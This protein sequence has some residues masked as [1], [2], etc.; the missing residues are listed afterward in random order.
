MSRGKVVINNETFLYR[1]GFSDSAFGGD[2]WTKFYRPED[3][4]FLGM[5]FSKSAFLISLDIDNIYHKKEHVDKEIA[6]SYNRWQNSLLR[7]E[8][9][10]SVQEI[11]VKIDSSK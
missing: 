7:I 2:H 1:T 10:K 4:N 9:L 8:E 6:D 5:R 11:T 3:V